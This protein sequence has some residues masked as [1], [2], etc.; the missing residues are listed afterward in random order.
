MAAPQGVCVAFDDVALEPNP[1]WTTL[2]NVTSWSIDRGRNVET[3]KTEAGT[4]TINLVDTVGD[5][6][7]TNVG[8]A[9][10]GLLDPMKQVAIAVQHPV[11]LT[12][13]TIYRGF[14][15]DWNYTLDPSENV[16]NVQIEC[17]D[18][19]DLL[20]AAEMTPGKFGS[21][22]VGGTQ[23]TSP[24]G[25][26]GDVFYPNNQEVDARIIQ[27]LADFGWPTSLQTIFS[28]NV[29]ERGTVYSVGDPVL[30]VI[31]DAADGEFP[32]VANLFIS[33]DGFVTFH[34]RFARFDPDTTSSGTSWAFH[35]WY[36]G[37]ADAVAGAPTVYAPVSGPLMFNRGKTNLFNRAAITPQGGNYPGTIDDNDIANQVVTDDVSVSQFGVRTIPFDNLVTLGGKTD[38]LNELQETKLFSNYYVANYA[39]PRTRVPQLVFTPKDPADANASVLFDLIVGVEISDIVHLN[40]THPGGGGFFDE[41][42]YVEG[43]HYDV[44]GEGRAFTD[45]TLTLDVSPASYYDASPF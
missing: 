3:D 35:R 38:G 19:F 23:G 11:A 32:G 14:V 20:A 9:Y 33:K 44:I 6:D 17:I 42:F 1:L 34:G 25:S 43:I 27:A 31:E 30:N 2:T 13:T 5:F 36:A 12:W 7:P 39:S 18:A 21:Y 10:Y 15:S 24:T 28:G 16:L 40:T 37:D 8:G 4:A 45:M 29:D 22:T 41:P 26:E